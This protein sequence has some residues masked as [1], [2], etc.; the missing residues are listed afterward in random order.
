MPKKKSGL[1]KK[2]KSSA[3]VKKPSV[4]SYQKDLADI[5]QL[6]HQARYASSRA[7]NA[8]MTAAYWEIGRRIVQAE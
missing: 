4:V 7:V 6:V 1:L 2:A 3:T 5:K 8:V